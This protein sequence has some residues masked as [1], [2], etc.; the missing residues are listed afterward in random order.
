MINGKY[1]FIV[2][3]SKKGK[4]PTSKRSM[5]VFADS[6]DEVINDYILQE[7]C[8][9]VHNFDLIGHGVNENDVKCLRTNDYISQYSIKFRNDNNE[10]ITEYLIDIEV[11]AVKSEKV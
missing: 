5:F 8:E 3:Y 11:Y 4:G 1:Q 9:K 6:Y 10:I 7:L 2:D